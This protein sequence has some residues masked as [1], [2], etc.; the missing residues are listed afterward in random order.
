MNNYRMVLIIQNLSSY[1][2]TKILEETYA[3][4]KNK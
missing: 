1:I 4:K 3:F 2:H